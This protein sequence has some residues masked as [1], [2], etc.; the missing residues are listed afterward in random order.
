MAICMSTFSSGLPEA[1]AEGHPID[2]QLPASLPLV[3]GCLS[4]T[5]RKHHFFCGLSQQE[6]QAL[7]EV[8][9]VIHYPARALV[10]VE[11]QS[12]RGVYIIC[13]G[14]VKLLASNPD[15]EMMIVKLAHAGEVLGLS[16]V[17]TDTPHELTA[18]TL[19]P[20]MLAFI[21]SQDLLR[22]LGRNEFVLLRA[23]QQ[24][25]RE[26]QS[27][28]DVIRNVGFARTSSVKLAR[29]LLQLSSSGIK[30]L[31]HE[32]MAQLVGSRR[33]TVTRTLADFRKRGILGIG[34]S[35]LNILDKAV[36]ERLSCGV[37][38]PRIVKA[39]QTRTSALY[40]IWPPAKIA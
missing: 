31:S 28:H 22:F 32:E 24:L 4:C 11:G 17:I 37:T 10:F 39:A 33:E 35:G 1:Q 29:L 12:N 18:E 27:A 8:K 14:R 26:V 7:D 2:A 3:D 25:G 34:A 5:L 23:A 19:Q 30:G 21:S 9:R 36:L 20:C 15:G 38:A 6:L 13:Q 16:S 40:S